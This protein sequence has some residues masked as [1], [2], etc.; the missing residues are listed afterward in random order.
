M[1]T[2]LLL[3]AL[4]ACPSIDAPVE[5]PTPS[6]PEDVAIGPYEVEVR[7]TEFGVPHLLAEDLGWKAL[8]VV[9]HA[10]RGFGNLA[11]EGEAALVGFAAGVNRYVE[12][13]SSGARTSWPTPTTTTG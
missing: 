3:L 13:P 9:G 10:E 5:A 4:A 12:P 2:L 7:W 11:P 8:D 1:R 6:G